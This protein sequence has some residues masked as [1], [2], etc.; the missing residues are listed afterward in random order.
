MVKVLKELLPI[1]SKIKNPIRQHD[2]IKKVA[3]RIEVDERWIIRDVSKGRPIVTSRYIIQKEKEALKFERMLIKF[4]LEDKEVRDRFI[5]QIRKEELEDEFCKDVIL[6]MK[7]LVSKG[8]VINPAHIMD[9]LD[10]EK[11]HVLSSLLIESYPFEDKF[12]LVKDLLNKIK[13]KDI[14]KKISYLQKE[15]S[16]RKDVDPA[17]HREYEGLVREK[18]AL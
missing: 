9:L 1:I 15:I 11:R 16:K 12:R 13:I 6:V 14:N 5:H 2:F 10:E 8:E 18:A 17:L 3:E 7:G 4:M